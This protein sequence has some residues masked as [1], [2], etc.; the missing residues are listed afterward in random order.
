MPPA[1]AVAVELG[2][3]CS[4]DEVSWKAVFARTWGLLTTAKD[5]TWPFITLSHEAACVLVESLDLRS[6]GDVIDSLE[7]NESGEGKVEEGRQVASML[8]AEAQACKFLSRVMLGN[9][10]LPS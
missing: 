7:V 1:E 5:E 2:H 9:E 6:G 8:H 10:I 3:G 4:A